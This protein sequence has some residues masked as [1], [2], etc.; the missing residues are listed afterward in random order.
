MKSL[1]DIATL[2]SNASI[3]DHR[4]INYLLTDSRSLVS[5][6]ETL[7][8][9]LHT[10]KGD[11]HHYIA[12]LLRKG[13]R[14]FVVQQIPTGLST[15]YPDASFILVEDTLKALHQV[16][17]AYRD[18]L[19]AT[20][21]AVT[22]S[23]GKT[24]F[25]ELLFQLLQKS[26]TTGRSPKSYNSAIGVP[27]SLWGIDSEAEYAI[28]EAGISEP[29]EM[30]RLAHTIRPNWG[31]I[32]NIGEAHQEHFDTL[33]Q[34][35]EEKVLLLRECQEVFAPMDIPLITE[36][37]NKA[38]ITSHCHFWSRVHQDADLFISRETPTAEGTEVHFSIGQKHYSYTF[39]FFDSGTLEDLYLALLVAHTIAP[40]L[41][42]DREL[43]THLLP[44]HMRLEVVRG[45]MDTL[46]INDTYSLDYNSLKIALDF[47]NRRNVGQQPTA[48]ILSDFQE[49]S[50]DLRELYHRV[51]DLV[52]EY[53]LTQVLLIG[54]EIT[55][56]ASCFTTNPTSVQC[57]A[58][59]ADFLQTNPLLSLQHHIILLKG[60]RI[61]GFEAIVRAMQRQTHQTILSVNL[62]NIVHNL[63]QQRSFLPK[64]MKTICMIKAGAY[65]VGSYEMARTLERAGVDFLAVALVDEGKE[66]REKGIKTPIIVMN[67]EVSS[68]AQMVELQ[69]QPE[70]YSLSLLKDYI[71]VVQDLGAQ[72]QPIHLKWDTGMHRLGMHEEDL[73]ALLALLRQ[74]PTEV[75]IAS[76][77]THL[78]VADDPAEDAYTKMQLARLDFITEQ[79]HKEI[80]Y[81]FLKHALNTAGVLRFPNY[82]SDAVRLGGGLYGISPM[83]DESYGLL[84]VSELTTVILQI[85][86][87]K[88]G[89]TVGY[90]RKGKVE[91]DA[92][93]AVI[94]IGYADGL[95]RQ[96]GNGH[97]T[98][99]LSDGTLVPTIGNIC[100]DTLMLD[101]TDA[102]AV[103]EGSQ[104]EI[105][106]ETLPISRLADACGTI[107]YEILSR[108]SSRI[109]RHYYTE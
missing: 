108:L 106:G 31:V 80:G 39:P 52:N 87:L 7:F 30:S 61:A 34:K 36:A 95:P 97:I 89:D 64:G 88:A 27:L 94:P 100:M 53:H 71:K 65:G 58:T 32:T 41:L 92:R 4:T 73:P 50:K 62:S 103:A 105:F 107:T 14:A 63:N 16:A 8:F 10:T 51:A 81:P 83:P 21:I 46:L 40:A 99:R 1:S 11:G 57:F 77:F 45:E 101:V 42:Q 86:H 43:L 90:G 54:E 104:V 18:E 59:L 60:S 48:L 22:G 67:P 2:L 75:H 78:A 56:Y 29:G 28:I 37:L 49:G 13:V 84:P 25:K 35:T 93:I 17:S 102:T 70:I 9:A 44:L 85:Q 20:V 47:Q 12:E 98:F 96:L 19:K 82:P 76:A 55:K 24:T 91:R 3:R 69:L 15:A 23:N 74:Y 66:L 38:E 79:L 109:T 33:E 6:Q 68:M 5:P 72:A 26:Y